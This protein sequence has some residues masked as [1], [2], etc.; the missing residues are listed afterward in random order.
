MKKTNSKR[1]IGKIRKS[2]SIK[3]QAKNQILHTASKGSNKANTKAYKNQLL[4]VNKDESDYDRI[5]QNKLEAQYREF[6]AIKEHKLQIKKFISAL[7]IIAIIIFATLL[8][9]IYG[10]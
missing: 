4:E 6:R 3:G 9:L 1:N 2:S 10:G 5:F 8:A 7:T